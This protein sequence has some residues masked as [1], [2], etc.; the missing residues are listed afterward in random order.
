MPSSAVLTAV[1]GQI[2]KLIVRVRFSSPAPPRRP[3]SETVSPAWALVVGSPVRVSG[4]AR[5]T[6]SHEPDLFLPLV[7]RGGQ[8]GAVLRAGGGAV[9]RAGGGAVLR[10]GGGGRSEPRGTTGS[11]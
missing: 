6:P 5:M 11:G 4:R 10:A 8:G 7:W 1:I 9:L 2:P 3:R